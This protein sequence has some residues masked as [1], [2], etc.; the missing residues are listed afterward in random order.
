MNI[1]KSL[2]S[3]LLISS[4]VFSACG[5]DQNMNEDISYADS[6]LKDF[7]NGDMDDADIICHQSTPVA[8]SELE[9]LT[10]ISGNKIRIEYMMIPPIQGQEDL[11]IVSDGEYMYMWGNSFLG[12]VMS[13]FKVAIG[14]ESMAAPDESMAEFVDFDMPM[15]D[16]TSWD[17]DPLY[18]TIP[19]DVDFMD[20][21]NLEETM[22]E[23]FGM[24]GVSIDCSICD[25]MPAEEKASCL[26][27]M[28]CEI[29]E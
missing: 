9:V 25:Q 6:S 8:G 23:D 26:E 3:I 14:S 5:S 2:L 7:I 21:D 1:K 28:G 10:Y 20:M 22:M 16:C 11:Y 15:I 24:G 13:G 18:F 17:V 19:D 4:F 12:G 29:E 27:A